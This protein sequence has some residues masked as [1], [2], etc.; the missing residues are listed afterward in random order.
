M[1]P[2][3]HEPRYVTIERSLRERIATMQPGDKLPSDAELCEEFDVSRMTARQAVQSLVHSGLVTRMPGRGTFVAH[4][5]VRRKMNSLLSFTEEMRRRGFEPSS[6][7]LSRGLEEPSEVEIAELGLSA[8]HDVVVVR[9]VRLANGTPMSI[10]RAA[11]HGDLAGVLE[12]E[13]E[14]GSLHEALR[15]LGRVP[16][17]ARGTFSCRLATT[18]EARL[19]DVGRPAP[20]LVERRLI[21]DQDG[22]PIEL[23]ES[24]YAGER[25][26]F[27]I[28]LLVEQGRA[29]AGEA[30]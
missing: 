17:V 19:L 2:P 9:R 20:L 15:A 6:R 28:E 1:P 14:T 8:R 22:A 7:V 27:D 11:L 13:L 26:V 30:T 3:A 23:T 5:P 16:T 25:Y 24:A 18:D 4:D 29:L 10:E 12:A 21:T